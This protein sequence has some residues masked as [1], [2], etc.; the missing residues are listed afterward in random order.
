M[1][2]VGSGGQLTLEDLTWSQPSAADSPGP[3]EGVEVI[4]AY[5]RVQA[6]EDGEIVDVS[7][8]SKDLFKFPVH[9]TRGAFAEAVE[10]SPEEKHEGQDET[11]RLWDVLNVLYF[12]ARAVAPGVSRINFEV[13][14]Y[15]GGDRRET[16]IVRI[17]PSR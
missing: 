2:G 10:V 4:Y 16:V 6:L 9:M 7:N 1:E 15:R 5:T 17:G 3:F 13:S 12:K 11:G 14:V 8:L